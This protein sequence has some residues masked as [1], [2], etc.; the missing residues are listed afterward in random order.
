MSAA[1][2]FLLLALAAGI[3]GFIA[4][5]HR[6]KDKRKC[7]LKNAAV[8]IP[9]LIAFF[10]FGPLFILSPVKIG[11][12]VVKEGETTFLYPK[13]TSSQEV[14]DFRGAALNAEDV[15]KDFYGTSISTRFLLANT[16]FDM[17]R[18]GTHPAAGGANG[19]GGIYIRKDKIDEGVIT[20]ELSHRYLAETVRGNPFFFPRWFDEGLAT[21][22]GH[23]GQMAKYTNDGILK[24]SIKEGTYQQDLS[25]W[26][27]LLGKLR[28]TFL[29]INR[30][31]IEIYTQ[32][33]FLVRFMIQ[34]YGEGQ[35]KSFLN[36][37]ETAKTFDAA[38][39]KV[40]GVT[41]SEFHQDFLSSVGE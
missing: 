13:K 5:F 23:M 25:Y 34:E 2:V 35:F 36:E 41:V 16:R 33:Y 40:Y 11:Y 39:K 3:L 28:W 22:L 1:Y 4:E 38:F 8:A 32:T 17:F 7:V 27:G 30:R 12:T 14:A 20:H 19:L 31:S 26:N 21:Y 6:A 37:C 15:V 9:I 24:D 10:L 18:F 29:D